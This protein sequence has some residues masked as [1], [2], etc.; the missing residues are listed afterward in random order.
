MATGIDCRPIAL[1]MALFT[2]GQGIHDTGSGSGWL[3][4]LVGFF[5]LK[6]QGR[7]FGSDVVDYPDCS[8]EACVVIFLLELVF[9][10]AFG[11]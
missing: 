10:D 5:G 9:C 8:G 1:L 4:F 6:L 2:S 3:D 7:H 11:D